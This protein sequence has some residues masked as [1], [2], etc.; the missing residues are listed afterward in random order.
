[1]T[2][3]TSQQE[4][5]PSNNYK[6]KI[7]LLIKTSLSTSDDEETDLIEEPSYKQKVIDCNGRASYT[8]ISSSG[9]N[10][11]FDNIY[12]SNDKYYTDNNLIYINNSNNYNF[13]TQVFQPNALL[14]QQNSLYNIHNN[15]TLPKL[16]PYLI[17]E[18]NWSRYLQQLINSD[19][20]FSN[21]IFFPFIKNQYSQNDLKDL[22]CD[23]FG[24]YLF[25]SLIETLNPLNLSEFLNMINNDLYQI[26]INNY[27]T[28]VI[29]KLISVIKN[30]DSFLSKFIEIL[31]PIVLNLL[32]ESHGNHIIQKYLEEIKNYE[33][34]LFIINIIENNFVNISTHK[35]GC[36][37]IQKFLSESID[38]K[39]KLHNFKLIKKN[40]YQIIYNQYG[41]Y[42]FQYIIEKEDIKMKIEILNQ[43]LPQLM[44]ICKTK[45]SS[46]VI[47]KCLEFSF[48]EIHSLILN[49]IC[50][51]NN[52]I[53]ELVFDSYGNYIIQKALFVCNKEHYVQIINI[54]GN[55]V[56][57]IKKLTF[58][59]KLISKLLSQHK[60][61]SEYILN[62]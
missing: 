34:K 58:G 51:N 38:C 59:N 46:N 10:N 25:Q 47:E 61:L 32:R 17:K 13:Y 52:N 45:Y 6:P 60:S 35:Y 14:Y 26:S 55:N 3:R 48:S 53:K 2:S 41:S 50:E 27:G 39:E 54:I 5:Q 15:F 49:K 8:T 56:E 43:L 40:L 7:E 42:I 19:K 36:C 24:N 21:E 28:R 4:I 20:Y 18:Q 12:E 31:N 33:H 37:T 44:K 29:Q 23:Q 11:S 1:M 57:K 30:N 16:S 9:N 22:I 62:K